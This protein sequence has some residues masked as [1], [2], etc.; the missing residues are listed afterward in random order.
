MQSLLQ[1]QHR[2]AAKSD[3]SSYF[4]Q[5][6]AT[7]IDMELQNANPTIINASELPT[8]RG[9]KRRKTVHRTGHDNTT[10][11]S[12]LHWDAPLE[13]HGLFG[14]LRDGHEHDD[15]DGGDPIDEQEIFG[16][17]YFKICLARFAI[18]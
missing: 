8:R 13:G 10:I 14:V 12:D 2:G 5:T 1:T 9:E 15:D 3:A 6:T 11:D 7:G 4:C 16:M 18:C 17:H